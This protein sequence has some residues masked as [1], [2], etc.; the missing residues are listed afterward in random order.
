MAF[1]VVPPQW[2]GQTAFLLAGGPSLKG[3]NASVLRGRGRVIAINNSWELAPWA[4]VLYFCDRSWW[5][6]HR[7]QVKQRFTGRYLV[8]LGV[9]EAGVHR[10]R[11]GG[12][13]GLSSDPSVLKHGTNSGYQAINLAYLFGAK[14]IVLLGYDMR[15]NP[16]ATH[17]HAGHPNGPTAKRYAQIIRDNMLPHF[18]S[19]VKPLRDAGVEVMNAT[20]DSALTAFPL[21]TIQAV[22]QRI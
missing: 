19:L 2:C 12:V 18:D 22:L 11:A 16:D 10:L 8:S 4:D 7:E 13:S 17:W 3:F 21:V 14:R 1:W 6:R 9:N 15:V 5:R 20:P